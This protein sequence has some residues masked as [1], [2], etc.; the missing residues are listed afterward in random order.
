MVD[1]AV[2]IKTKMGRKN[3]RK[4]GRDS[5]KNRRMVASEAR[6]G[7]FAKGKM[8]H[9]LPNGFPFVLD[10]RASLARSCSGRKQ[11]LCK[12]SIVEYSVGEYK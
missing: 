11:S 3:C 1:G 2:A 10:L 9:N 7:T 4:M 5:G 6:S 12:Y 8:S